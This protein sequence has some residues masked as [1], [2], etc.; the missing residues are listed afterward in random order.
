M[1]DL[2]KKRK[3][4]K[5]N[6]WS[7][8][9]LTWAGIDAGDSLVCVHVCLGWRGSLCFAALPFLLKSRASVS[10]QKQRLELHEE[11]GSPSPLSK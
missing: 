11:V 1:Q 3:F 9:D 5:E 4:K 8:S 6:D 10:L 7:S 2:K